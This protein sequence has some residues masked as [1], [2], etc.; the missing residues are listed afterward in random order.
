MILCESSVRFWAR[1]RFQLNFVGTRCLCKQIIREQS[2]CAPL[3]DC[4][5]VYCDRG[6]FSVEES[7]RILEAGKAWGSEFGR[8]LNKSLIPDA[9]TAELGATSV[10]HLER[11]DWA[12]VEAMAANE[13]VAV[14]LPGAQLYLKDAAPPWRCFV[15][16]ACRWPLVRISIRFVAS[17]QSLDLCHTGLLIQGFTIDE[18]VIGMTEMLVWLGATRFGLDWLGKCRIWRC[19]RP[20]RVSRRPS[21]VWFSIWLR[22]GRFMMVDW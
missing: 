3:A 7:L 22:I 11:I 21:R 4:V 16:R 12:G 2:G 18:A 13:T 10:D 9:A 17:A 6:A 5:D 14:L 1:I 15:K 20:L 8:M 19:L